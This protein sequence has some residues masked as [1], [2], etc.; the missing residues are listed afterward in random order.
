M[1]LLTYF[2][3]HPHRN[4]I[5]NAHYFSIYERHFSRFVGNS[6]T[7]LEIGTGE[8]GS[9]QMWKHYFG[10]RARIVTVDIKDNS[11]CA[12]QQIFP[13]QGDQADPEFLGRIIDE[14]GPPDIV[15]D[16]G[17]HMM[18]DINASFDFL[19]P[20]MSSN[21]VYLV[22]DLD[23]AYWPQRGGGLRHPDSF[24]ERCKHLVDEM[25]Y[26]YTREINPSPANQTI[27]SV[28]FYP[29]VVVIERAQSLNRHMV[30]APVPLPPPR[31]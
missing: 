6:V 27:V 26:P 7:M 8:G 5:K 14:F 9:C 12:E 3:L 21:G 1:D 31:Q 10:P 17:S 28:C 30:R 22:E 4:I 18:R 25:H 16:D 23:G 20:T 2:L 11:A 19:F 29:M 13:Q 24:V 15:M